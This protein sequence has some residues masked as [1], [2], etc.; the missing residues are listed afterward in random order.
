[1]SPLKLQDKF[2]ELLTPI[3]NGHNL[4]RIGGYSDG[5]YWLP[6]DLEGIKLCISPGYGNLSNFEDDLFEKFKIKSLIIDPQ[7]PN[8]NLKKHL[9]FLQ[10]YI[11]GFN[12]ITYVSLNEIMGKRKGDYLMQ[13]DIEG[14]ELESLHA[15]DFKNLIKFRIIVLELHNLQ[16]INNNF[17]L[18]NFFLPVFTKIKQKFDVISVVPSSTQSF[19][20]GAMRIPDTFEIT[21]HRKDRRAKAQK[22]NFQWKEQMRIAK[23]RKNQGAGNRL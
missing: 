10:K 18:T 1:M 14:S 8:K 7:V 5:G 22:I 12:S 11:G 6:E 19:T 21:F 3:S 17:L 15:L 13:M 4:V 9:R 20:N 16:L 23:K 2:L